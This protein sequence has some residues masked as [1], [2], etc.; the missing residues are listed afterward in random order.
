MPGVGVGGWDLFRGPE[1][2]VQAPGSPPQAETSRFPAA[3]LASPRLAPTPALAATMMS[4]GPLLNLLPALPVPGQSLNAVPGP[5][6]WAPA[7]IPSPLAHS[8]RCHRHQ[9]TL[10]V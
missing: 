9:T 7:C 4:P 8:F 3:P 6:R 1:M 10:Q 2:W 5:S